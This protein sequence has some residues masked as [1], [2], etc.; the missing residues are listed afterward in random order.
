M[1][2]STYVLCENMPSGD[3]LTKMGAVT[4]YDLG[5]LASGSNLP[6]SSLQHSHRMYSMLL[7]RPSPVAAGDCSVTSAWLILH[8]LDCRD[9]ILLCSMA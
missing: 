6:A 1:I 2:I 3:R 4:A 9:V 8:R 7:G 5:L